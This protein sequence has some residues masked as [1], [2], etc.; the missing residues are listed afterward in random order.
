MVLTECVCLCNSEIYEK[1]FKVLTEILFPTVMIVS[2]VTQLISQTRITSATEIELLILVVGCIQTVLSTV[3]S[4]MFEFYWMSNVVQIQPGSFIETEKIK[5]MFDGRYILYF[6]SPWVFTNMAS[7]WYY[8][9]YNHV[10]NWYT[11][12][13]IYMPILVYVLILLSGRALTKILRG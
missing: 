4:F 5:Y 12:L 1:I 10:F 3:G 13:M 11:H 6:L 9:Y 2:I 8:L 7:S